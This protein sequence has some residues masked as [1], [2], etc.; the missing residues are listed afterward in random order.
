MES[1]RIYNCGCVWYSIRW[2]GCAYM[3]HVK[4]CTGHPTIRPCLIST[5]RRRLNVASSLSALSPKGSQKPMGSWTPS[6]FAGS[7]PVL[8]DESPKKF[9][10]QL[11]L[12]KDLRAQIWISAVGSCEPVQESTHPWNSLK[13]P[14]SIWLYNSLLCFFGFAWIDNWLL[15]WPSFLTSL[16]D[17]FLLAASFTREM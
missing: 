5:A 7:N 8:A 10:R 11:E 15:P 1:I 17:L 16:L 9:L 14:E 13:F 4:T 3:K 12:L 6:C 2:W